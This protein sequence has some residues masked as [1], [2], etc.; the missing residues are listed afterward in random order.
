MQG[1][2]INVYVIELEQPWE[3]W[4]GTWKNFQTINKVSGFYVENNKGDLVVVD[5]RNVFEMDSNLPILEYIHKEANK[6]VFKPTFPLAADHR[7]PYTNA[8]INK[9]TKKTKPELNGI[10]NPL[11][12]IRSMAKPILGSP[13]ITPVLTTANATIPPIK[14]IKPFLNV[15]FFDFL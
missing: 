1:Q 13:V 14:A 2:E 12:N 5:E 9:A 11:T 6:E 10:P 3:N 4:F 7:I 15:I 8:P